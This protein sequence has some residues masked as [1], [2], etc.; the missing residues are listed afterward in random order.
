MR[1]EYYFSASISSHFI[2]GK[3]YTW[4]SFLTSA[5][6]FISRGEKG[7]VVKRGSWQLS[8][9]QSTP[10]QVI[11]SSSVRGGSISEKFLGFQQHTCQGLN[12]VCSSL[13]I[14]A[15][16]WFPHLAVYEGQ[17]LDRTSNLLVEQKWEGQVITEHKDG[18]G[19]RMWAQL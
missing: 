4:A 3:I 12:P 7:E 2:F 10:P 19:K 5:C 15:S 6:L 17:K 13:R 16:S 1:A 9:A 18:S 8:S 11:P 14:L